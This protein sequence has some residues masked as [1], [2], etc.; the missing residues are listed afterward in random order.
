MA[1]SSK[2]GKLLMMAV[3]G[4]SGLF[5]GTATAQENMPHVASTHVPVS[6]APM[7][8]PGK[9]QVKSLAFKLPFRI[10]PRTH[11]NVQEMHLWS[12]DDQ[13][14]WL[15]MDRVSPSAGFFTCRVG[16]DGEYGFSIVTVD[17]AGKVHPADVSRRPPELLV[18]VH[19][20]SEA[21]SVPPLSPLIS[22]AP[23]SPPLSL[24][25]QTASTPLPPPIVPP[26]APPLSPSVIEKKPLAAKTES[27]IPLVTDISKTKPG[28]TVEVISETP[29][30]M[31]GIEHSAATEQA[32]PGPM[33]VSTS[34]TILINSTQVSVDYNIN[35]KG[36]SGVSKVEIYGT[37]DGGQS[38]KRFGEDADRVSPALVTLPGE[39]IFGLR[40]T[41]INGNGFGKPPAVGA[42]PTTSIEVDT[43]RPKIQS[44]SATPI[45]DGKLEIQWL[46]LDKNLGNAPVNL[47]YAH[48]RGGPWK[49]LCKKLKGE[50][51][52]RGPVPSDAT[53]QLMIR[54]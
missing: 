32:A 22:D 7:N 40:L 6:T 52:F 17:G 21:A 38:W 5:V 46:V 19:S 50:A 37:T 44:W 1:F 18:V 9:Y 25:P 27:L 28:E 23:A 10:D 36:P 20:G 12:C 47:Y 45:K 16:Q 13:G 15:I 33:P 3:L 31:A 26:V 14:V 48:D 24:A 41:G 11:A 49:P 39:G 4:A 34:T 53:D 35:R 2:R 29:L 42:Q 43:T 8:A 51:V 54:L 30:T